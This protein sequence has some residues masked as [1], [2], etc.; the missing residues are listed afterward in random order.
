[1]TETFLKL[2]SHRHVASGLDDRVDVVLVVEVDEGEVHEALLPHDGPEPLA[3][4]LVGQVVLRSSVRAEPRVEPHGA[5]NGQ[6][7]RS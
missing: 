3:L 6:R 4:V 1:M 7:K 5:E 2:N